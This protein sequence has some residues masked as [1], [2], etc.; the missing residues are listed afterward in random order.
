MSRQRTRWIRALAF[1]AIVV[2]LGA[3]PARAQQNP[4]LFV[5]QTPNGTDFTNLMSTFGNHRGDANRAPRGG[6][7]WIRYPDGS[8]RNLTAEAGYGLT[9]G[10][11]IAV[12]DPAP[13]FDG[14]RALFSM[15]I[16]GT[17][18]D[19]YAPVYFQI[20]EV[21][22]FGVGQT[23]Q[24]RKL[25]QPAD[26]NNV[27][28]IYGSDG[29]ILFTSDRPR[30]GDRRLYPQLDEY[31]T[32]PTVSGLW[33]MNADGSDLALLDHS[34]SGVFEPFVDSFGRVVFTRWDHLQRDQQADADVVDLL[35]G[36][37][38]E[39]GAVTYESEASDV[40]HPLAP[41]DEVFPEPRRSYGDPLWD[42]LLPGEAGHTFSMFLPWMVHQDGTGLETLDHL[43]R[44]ELMDRIA[45]SR[46]Y[47]SYD[48][49]VED[50]LELFLHISEDPTSPGTYFGIR[51]PEFGT[52]GAGQ[53]VS[54]T[55]PPGAN[56]DSI[57]VIHHTHPATATIVPDGKSPSSS[58]IG[59]FRDPVRLTDGTLIASHTTN[60]RYEDETV[61]NPAYPKPYKLSSRNNFAIKQ[62][63]P[64]TNGY[65]K[66]G[67]R[68]M[69]SSIVETISYFDNGLY[70][71][72]QYSG[73]LWELQPVEVIPRPAPPIGSEPLPAIEQAVLSDELGDDGIAA[74]RA[75]LR[76]N[77][78]ALITSRDV[79]VRA[80]RQQDFDLAVAWSGHQTA[81]PGAVPKE[82]A[83]LQLFEGQQLRGFS[84]WK[85]R[86]V[87]ARPSASAPNPPEPTAPPGAVRLGED[88][89][90]AAFVPARRA[91]T[92]QT[93][94]LD[95]T[96]AVRERYWLTFQPGEIRTCTNC[97]GV[98]TTDVF[99]G[100]IPENE[101]AALRTLAAW[102]RDELLVP[103]PRASL[104]AATACATLAALARRRRSA[105]LR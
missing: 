28:P 90:M 50:D 21:T 16:G 41:H 52:R 5:T 89:S 25:T 32:R 29:R 58:H 15:V 47:L 70:R 55:A 22:G 88:G 1:A 67:S 20:Y 80:D 8:R 24:I 95:G 37:T 86:R 33:S 94:T 73:A 56:A 27:S 66:V 10:Q 81:T 64:G 30:N 34:P 54:I 45:P 77:E 49:G 76:R 53:L 14:T 68:L 71:T 85:G 105:R 4:I 65:L 98:N 104:L 44:H 51:S 78:L 18:Q 100:P 84:G 13:H 61:N 72:V 11:E 40:H 103:E 57:A 63:V 26:T 87:L 69:S 39:Y 9:P 35:A 60:T 12:R 96:P 38:P 2:G 31:E 23:V 101:P 48:E 83:W 62:L 42:A 93:T 3:A 79:T 82:L 92:W 74:L 19:D 46:T 102:W 43:G 99:G 17:T 36:R 59:M 75:W 7:L 6:D 91:L 97:H